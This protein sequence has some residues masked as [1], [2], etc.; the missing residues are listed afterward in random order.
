MD[1]RQPYE[2]APHFRQ[3]YGFSARTGEPEAGQTN[4]TDYEAGL[5]AGT[6][7][8]V[9]TEVGAASVTP[10]DRM[11][12]IGSD[13]PSGSGS[14]GW[15]RPAN[16]RCEGLGN[17]ENLGPRLNEGSRSPSLLDGPGQ[18]RIRKMVGCGE[19]ACQSSQSCRFWRKFCKSCK[20]GN[21]QV[22]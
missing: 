20:F 6:D 1:F 21:Q 14:V 16:K 13:S 7:R 2:G 22:T 11:K 12:A 10:T 18:S 9:A 5:G 17:V 15:R 8:C 3:G 19:F 4:P